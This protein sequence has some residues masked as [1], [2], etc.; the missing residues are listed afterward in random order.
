MLLVQIYF[1]PRS[2][3]DFAA[4]SNLLGV[5]LFHETVSLSAVE[6]EARPLQVFRDAATRL[7]ENAQI[8]LRLGMT[9]GRSLAVTFCS[10]GNVA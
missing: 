5:I 4:R 10:L 9:L 7:V 2:S 8:I 1:T 3:G 6:P